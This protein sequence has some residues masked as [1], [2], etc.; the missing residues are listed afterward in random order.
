MVGRKGQ[1]VPSHSQRASLLKKLLTLPSLLD[2]CSLYGCIEDDAQGSATTICQ[3]MVA[4]RPQL[5]LDL[6]LKGPEIA[7]NM[8]NVCRACIHALSDMDYNASTA[9]ISVKEGVQ[10][11]YDSCLT[12]CAVLKSLPVAAS[13]LLKRDTYLLAALG[14]L[15]DQL[16]PDL[17]SRMSSKG[18][19]R[20]N[21]I[22]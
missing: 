5:E 10:Y 9:L 19:L 4:L 21:K 17:N 22:C 2:V 20:K 15:H 3:A 8:E 13:C 11:L 7:E 16:V 1:G 18:S 12:L 14:V 6:A